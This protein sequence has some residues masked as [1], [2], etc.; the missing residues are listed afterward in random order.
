[1]ITVEFKEPF[2]YPYGIFAGDEYTYFGDGRFQ[3]LTEETKSLFDNNHPFEGKR[4]SV[5]LIDDI[6]K[7]T[8]KGKHLYLTGYYACGWGLDSNNN[9]NKVYDYQIPNSEKLTW[10]DNIEEVP[11][12]TILN[13][14][15]GDIRLYKTLEEVPEKDR[16]I[17][18]K[19][20]NFWCKFKRTC[21]EK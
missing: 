14:E 17:F 21:F 10:F 1:M 18:E 15:T 8:Q 7:Y 11:R 9:N 4:I 6:E 12:Y 19:D 5:C 2:K 13:Y 16:K 3:I 20:L